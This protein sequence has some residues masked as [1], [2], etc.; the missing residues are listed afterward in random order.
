MSESII[1]AAL[2]IEHVLVPDAAEAYVGRDR[3]IVV[4][5]AVFNSIVTAHVIQAVGRNA[6]GPYG[7][8]MLR[9][10]DDTGT[11]YPVSSSASGGYE[12]GQ[13]WD[14]SYMFTRPA[15]TSPKRL[16]LFAETLGEGAGQHPLATVVVPEG[17]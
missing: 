8:I 1:P 10:F 7:G 2:E 12:N 13:P 14:I 5:I 3:Y 6:S 11:S 15:G 16:E 17:R 4:A 9:L